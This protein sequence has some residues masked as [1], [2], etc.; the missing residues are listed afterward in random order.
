MEAAERDAKT[1]KGED[2]DPE[3]E[4]PD[5]AKMHESAQRADRFAKARKAREAK[6]NVNA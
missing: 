2:S 6:C 3:E 4:N 5:R 1:I